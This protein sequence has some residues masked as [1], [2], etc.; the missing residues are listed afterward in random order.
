MVGVRAPWDGRRFHGR[1]RRCHGD[2]VEPGGPQPAAR[3]FSAIIE[4]A[5]PID[6]PGEGLRGDVVSASRPSASAITACRR[7][8]FA[9][10]SLQPGP[11]EAEKMRAASVC[12][13]P[14]SANPSASHLVLGSTVKAPERA[15]ETEGGLDL[16]AM[17]MFGKTRVGL[18]VRN[19]TEP[20]FGDGDADAE[21]PGAV[22]GR[23]QRSPPGIRGAIG[24]P[25]WPFDADLVKTPTVLR[26][27]AADRRRRR[28]SGCSSDGLA[29]RGAASAPARPASADG[30]ERRCERGAP[31][32][33]RIVDAELTGRRRRRGAPRVGASLQE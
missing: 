17:V 6:R 33:A 32:R 27:G 8:K 20:E 13:A 29:S 5:H 31:S 21:A 7:P 4:Y 24:T 10:A 12:S 11:A 1:G 3:Y 22:P 2:L 9:P 28:D 23:G 15:G 18:M 26:R 25:P 14:P 16:G 19:V 30:A